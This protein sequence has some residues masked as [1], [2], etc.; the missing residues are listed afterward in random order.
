MDPLPFYL[1]DVFAENK[2]EGNQLAVFDNAENLATETMQAIAKETNLAETT[3]ITAKR[4]DSYDVRIFTTEYEMPFAGHPTIGTAATIAHKIVKNSSQSI[5]LNLKIGPVTVNSNAGLFGFTLQNGSISGEI[6]ALDVAQ[7]LG[8]SHSDLDVYPYQISSTGYPFLMVGIRRLE[9]LR[10]LKISTEEMRIFLL[11]HK[12]HKSNSTDG[13]T[14]GIFCFCLET[15][16]KENDMHSRMF[17]LQ[18]NTIWEDPATGS[19]HTA[20]AHYANVQKLFGESFQK[21]SEQGFEMGRPSILHIGA[22][23]EGKVSLAGKVQFVASGL[24]EV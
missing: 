9:A 2:L 16:K 14:V 22:D 7:M 3:F 18:E 23:I 6:P 10:N 15:E 5:T 19:A 24:W 20:F 11:E 8:L 21:R 12:L 13:Y 4:R 1:V 17:L